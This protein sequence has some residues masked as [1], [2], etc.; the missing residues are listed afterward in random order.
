MKGK[1]TEKERN[2]EKVKGN[3]KKQDEKG[4]KGEEKK[5]NNCEQA[6]NIK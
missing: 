2:E 3:K 5:E 1:I 4:R 6:N